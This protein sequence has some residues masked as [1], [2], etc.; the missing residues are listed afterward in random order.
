MESLNVL[1]LKKLPVYDQL[2][3]IN[4]DLLLRVAALIDINDAYLSYLAYY[5]IQNLLSK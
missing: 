3:P 2:K 5:T 4:F 1:S